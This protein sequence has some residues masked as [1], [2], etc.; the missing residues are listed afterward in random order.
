MLDTNTGIVSVDD[1]R[2]LRETLTGLSVEHRARSAAADEA[3]RRITAT[4]PRGTA[5]VRLPYVGPRKPNE[6]V[7]ALADAWEAA[8]Y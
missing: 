1:E 5:L 2:A 6:I 8:G 7:L 3:T 4:A